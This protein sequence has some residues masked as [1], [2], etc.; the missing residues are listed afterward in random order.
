MIQSTET[1]RAVLLGTF[2][3][4]VYKNDKSESAFAPLHDSDEASFRLAAAD[5]WRQ[6]LFTLRIRMYTQTPLP[7]AGLV[8]ESTV[9]EAKTHFWS[10][11][12]ENKCV[13][14][15]THSRNDW[16]LPLRL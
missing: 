8:C 14:E 7:A 15:N 1:T 11:S 13:G 5:G 6:L 10:K 12:K 4:A 3:S 2:S 9:A 16:G